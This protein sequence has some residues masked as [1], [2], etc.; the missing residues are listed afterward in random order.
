MKTQRPPALD[1]PHSSQGSEQTK[2]LR[3][4]FPVEER[5]MCSSVSACRIEGQKA[6]RI[7]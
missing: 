1:Y 4:W 7:D 6:R 2:E 3:E 5:E